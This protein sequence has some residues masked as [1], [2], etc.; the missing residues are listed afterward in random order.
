MKTSDPSRSAGGSRV[1]TVTLAT[2][3]TQCIAS[4]VPGYLLRQALTAGHD[5]GT[6][7]PDE[8]QTMIGQLEARDGG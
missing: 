7:T 2:A 8:T 4:G 3:I 6:L 1:P 5:R